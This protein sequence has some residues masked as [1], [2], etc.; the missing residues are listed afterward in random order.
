MDKVVIGT[1]SKCAGPV[2]IM[3]PHEYQCDRCGE[4][5]GKDVAGEYGVVV[6]QRK[7]K[8]LVFVDDGYGDL[9]CPTPYGEYRIYPPED[10]S[11]H[12]LLE[13][14][15]GT[16]SEFSSKEYAIEIAN[17]IHESVIARCL[18]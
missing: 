10:Y 8:K 11:E 4:K 2:V 7:P 16:E 17:D 3:G 1:C 12:F 15:N 5:Y 18:E 14:A 6:G 13:T 9:V